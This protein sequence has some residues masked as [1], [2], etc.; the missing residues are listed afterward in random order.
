MKKDLDW[1]VEDRKQEIKSQP[2]EWDVST[3]L[4]A[5]GDMGRGACRRSK[6]EVLQAP[7]ARGK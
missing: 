1:S 3:V 6:D 4:H 2:L 5:H 7:R